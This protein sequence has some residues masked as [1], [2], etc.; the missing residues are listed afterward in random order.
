[1]SPLLPPFLSEF[2]KGNNCQNVLLR[3][4]DKCKSNI[5]DAGISG[6]LLTDL[7]KAFDNQSYRLSVAKLNVYRFKPD[8]CMLIANYFIN[9]LQRIKNGIVKS[10]WMGLEKGAPKGSMF[11][12]LA[13][14]LYSNDLLY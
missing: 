1:M 14:N 6:A 5:D 12:S 3:L 8:A 2:T 10:G 7:S 9:R 11:D 4:I 13:Y